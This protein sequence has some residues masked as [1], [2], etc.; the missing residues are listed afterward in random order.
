MPLHGSLPSGHATEAFIVV[1]LLE[2]L[3]PNGRSYRDTLQRLAARTSINRTVAGVRFPIDSQAGR[4]LGQSLG[5]YLVCLCRRD[6]AASPG[7]WNSRSFVATDGAFDFVVGTNVEP[8]DRQ[9]DPQP[10][11]KAD[12]PSALGWLWAQARAEWR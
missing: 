7:S 6:R 4:M 3:L 9:T 12:P 1:H 11:R 2:R 10:R 8:G 5:E